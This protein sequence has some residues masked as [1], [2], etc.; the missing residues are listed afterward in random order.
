MSQPE[1]LLGI[2]LGTTFSTAA[3]V[4]DGKFHFALD[5]RGE[6]C[7]PS[8]VYFPKAGAPVVGADADKMRATDP[9]NTIF[10]IKRVIAQPPDSPAARL[11]DAMAAF[12]LKAHDS[13]EAAVQV[14]A[15]EVTASEVASIILRY[16]KE[17]AE[18][19][20]GRKLGRAVVTVPVTA[21]PAVKDA[22]VRIGRMAGLEVVRVVSEPVAGALSRGLGG[23]AAARGPV[24]VYDFGGGTFDATVVQRVGEA[25]QVLASGGDSC[26]GGDDFDTAFAR[27]V[28]SA[29]WGVH[30]L[31]VTKDAILA[32]RIMRQCEAVKRLLSSAPEARFF[33]PDA[34]GVP[35]QRRSVDLRVRRDQLLLP[36]AELV[37][38][39]VTVSQKTLAAA[40]I[41]VADLDQVMLIGGTTQVPQVRA[42]VARAFPRPQAVEDD[43]QTA[44]ARGA[45]LLAVL[46]KLLL[47]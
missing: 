42:A 34:L 8:V 31:D 26:L 45:A 21:T 43:P 40:A 9:Q 7:V 12:R 13:G 19:R 3:A 35:G 27:Y 36:W 16:L 41:E 11:L 38:R 33:L 30:K 14:R 10:G 1:V 20:F 18:L 6:A 17:R 28:A 2:D 39:S 44:V 25:V 23:K 46:P 22:M 47:D 32:D 5:G 24:L 29:L 4:I 37:E 15:G